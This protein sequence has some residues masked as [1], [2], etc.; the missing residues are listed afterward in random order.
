MRKTRSLGTAAAVTAAIALGWG[1]SAHAGTPAPAPA[2]ARAAAAQ[3]AHA[4]AVPAAQTRAAAKWHTI[5]QSKF[6]PRHSKWVSGAFGVHAYNVTVKYRCWN[7]GDGTKAKASLVEADYPYRTLGSH[8]Y[9]YCNG[10]WWTFKSTKVKPATPY[11]VVV[12]QNHGRTHT[13]QVGAYQ[14]Y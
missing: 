6:K 7:G 1:G 9:A 11:K 14:Y 3:A 5:W 12:Q 8:S 2:P 13:E 4:Q 10:H